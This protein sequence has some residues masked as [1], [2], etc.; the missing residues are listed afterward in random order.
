[1]FGRTGAVAATSG[2]YSFSLISGSLSATQMPA[3]TGDVTSTAGTTATIVPKLAAVPIAGA[4]GNASD[5]LSS[6]TSGS[7]VPLTRLAHCFSIGDSYTWGSGSLNPVTDSAFAILT[8][9]FPCVPEQRGVPGTTTPTQAL[10][11]FQYVWH[12]PIYPSWFHNGTFLNDSAQDTCGGTAG[13]NCVKNAVLARDAEIMHEAIPEG[14][15]KVRASLLSGSSG[16]VTADATIPLYAPAATATFGTAMKITSSG[17]QIFITLPS[18]P[19]TEVGLTYVVGNALTGSFNVAIQDGAGSFI[20]QTDYC[21]GT[22]TFVNTGCGGQALFLATTTAFRQ[23]FAVTANTTHVIRITTLSANSVPIISADI[24]P[25][26]TVTNR[27]IVTVMG[28]PHIASGYGSTAI[29]DA[30][31]K[32]LAQAE[33]AA[34]ATVFF[35]DLAAGTPGMNLTTDVSGVA[36]T[37]CAGTQS[38]NHPNGGNPNQP[39][40]NCGQ[41]HMAQTVYNALIASGYYLGTYNGAGNNIATTGVINNTLTLTPSTSSLLVQQGAGTPGRLHQICPFG[42]SFNATTPCGIMLSSIA[43]VYS[44]I[45]AIVDGS[46]GTAWAGAAMIQ[47]FSPGSFWAGFAAQDGVNSTTSSHNTVRWATQLSTGNSAQL[48]SATAP[49]FI[50]SGTA[51]TI[52][53]GAGAGTSP[54]LAITG[55]NMAGVVTLTAGTTP[56]AS[57][58]VG[59]VTF[60]GTVTTAPKGCSV[61]PQNL[62]TIGIPVGLSAAP[63]TGGWILDVGATAFTAATVYAWNYSCF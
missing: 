8:R 14:P 56:S 42:T 26:T 2:D 47:T 52:A 21:S 53:A 29:Y 16:T 41:D 59:T 4:S 61:T 57:A 62:A 45:E 51:P 40:T 28:S 36:T 63:T 43:N 11:A 3:L 55:A 37:S 17:G 24:I 44:G 9:N 23:S 18:S 25:P 15:Y 27:G 34:G 32:A 46:T 1:M 6:S 30:A 31:E 12:D 50:A 20:A 5:L 39:G 13:T 22:A 54:T 7:V 60:S 38:T 10:S 49:Q 48:G 35:A 58:I 33:N 19:F